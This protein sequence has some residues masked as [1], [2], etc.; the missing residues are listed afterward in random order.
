MKKCRCIK[1]EY[2]SFMFQETNKIYQY[3]IGTLK[4]NYVPD[5][6]TRYYIYDLNKVFMCSLLIKDFTKYYIDLQVE[7][8]KK[9][10][11]IKKAS[12]KYTGTKTPRILYN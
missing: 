10:N 6:P 4:D 8:K 5:A 3:E 7:R 9:L 11:K 1:T 12:P 2:P